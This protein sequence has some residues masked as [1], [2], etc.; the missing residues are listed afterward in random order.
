VLDETDEAKRLNPADTHVLDNLREVV[1]YG[2][3]QM[4]C[5]TCHDV[6]K[7]TSAKHRELPVTQYCQHCHTASDP[8]KS[9]KRYTVHSERCEY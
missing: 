1:L 6:H 8:I 4:T 2:N 3:E 7:S 5:L 9:H